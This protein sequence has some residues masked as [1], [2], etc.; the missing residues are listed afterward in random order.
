MTNVRSAGR[1]AGKGQGDGR[2]TGKLATTG[3]VDVP[4]D[5]EE[6]DDG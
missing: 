4:L 3:L 6:G 1:Q 5:A 2:L